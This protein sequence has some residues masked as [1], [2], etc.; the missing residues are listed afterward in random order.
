MVTALLTVLA[1]A[2]LGAGGWGAALIRSEPRGAGEPFAASLA[3]GR[4][5]LGASLAAVALL[6]F[7]V[8][9]LVRP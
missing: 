5:A 1:L 4:R 6:A 2:A 9:L 8:V 3:R 7:V